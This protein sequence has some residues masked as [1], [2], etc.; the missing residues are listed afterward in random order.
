M[1]KLIAIVVHFL[2]VFNLAAQIN[3]DS[4]RNIAT[5]NKDDSSK[6]KALVQLATYY[7]W[8]VPDS[9]IYYAQIGLPLAE[10]LG[11]KQQLKRLYARMGEALA[12]KGSY[13]LALESQ[14][15][16]LELAEEMGDSSEISW[17]FV[18]VGSVYFYSHDYHAA[19]T[20]YK[21]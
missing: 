13:A 18:G 8:T 20:Y 5:A 4:A 16:G 21:K 12:G 9:T 10:K 2:L 6:L 7:I 14:L 15:K 11:S 17:S 1:T 19:L 3:V